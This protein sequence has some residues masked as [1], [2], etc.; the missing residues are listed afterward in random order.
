MTLY[1]DQRYNH[2]S[3]IYATFS[4]IRV[5]AYDGSKWIIDP[6]VNEI[7]EHWKLRVFEK[8]AL[9]MLQ[10]DLRDF[11]GKIHLTVWKKSVIFLVLNW[12]IHFGSSMQYYITG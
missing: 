9:I 2:R 11:G 1:V 8:K 7:K 10:W 4:K 5:L 12:M 3:C 6:Q